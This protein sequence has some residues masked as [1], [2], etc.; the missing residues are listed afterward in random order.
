MGNPPLFINDVAIFSF[1]H[2]T[3]VRN[4]VK[5]LARSSQHLCQIQVC[6]CWLPFSLNFGS[7]FLLFRMSGHFLLY[8]RYCYDRLGVCWFKGFK[9]A[10]ASAGG[11]KSAGLCL[12]ESVTPKSSHVAGCVQRPQ[13]LADTQPRSGSVYGAWE[14]EVWSQTTWLWIPNIL[15]TSCI[16]FSTSALCAS[17]TRMMQIRIQYLLHKTVGI[18]EWLCTCKTTG[19]AP[20]IC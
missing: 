9:S 14:F 3:C 8:A 12:S 20:A 5:V 18:I 2:Q 4:C 19:A 6:F 11:F 15:I 7:N 17:I 16:S 1:N 10:G 13:S